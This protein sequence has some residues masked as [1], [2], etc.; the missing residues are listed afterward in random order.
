[1]NI[2]TVIVSLKNKLLTDKKN[3]YIKYRNS[4]ASQNF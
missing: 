1:M 4:N 2:L 3:D